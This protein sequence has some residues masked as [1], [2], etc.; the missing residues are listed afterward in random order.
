MLS[1]NTTNLGD[2]YLAAFNIRDIK[3]VS[4]LLKLVKTISTDPYVRDRRDCAY[5][6][7]TTKHETSHTFKPVREIGSNTYFS[8]YAYN[9]QKGRELG[10]TRPGDDVLYSGRGFVQIT[11]RGQY[12]RLGKRLN[13]DLEA[14]PELALDWDV[15]YKIMSIGMGEGLFTGKRLAQ[16]RTQTTTDYVGMRRVINGSD[17]AETIAAYARTFYKLLFVTN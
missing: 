2:R 1:C 11:G 9:T 3:N 14:K 16:F 13:I 10:N 4:N 8:K 15:A 6:L 12:A 17:E 7:A 5:M